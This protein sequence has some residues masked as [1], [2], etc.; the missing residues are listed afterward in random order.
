MFKETISHST[1]LTASLHPTPNW[2]MTYSTQYDYTDGKFATHEFTF[3]RTLH[4][5]QLDF[6]WTRPV[7]PPGGVSP[8]TSGS[9]GYRLMRQAP[10]IDPSVF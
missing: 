8:S 7:L 3:N 1:S 9:A 4:C 2:E 5:W 6:T 10:M